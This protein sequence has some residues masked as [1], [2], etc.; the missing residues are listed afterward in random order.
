LQSQPGHRS[1]YVHS[2]L[3]LGWQVHT[4]VA[5]I[6]P[7]RWGLVDIFPPDCP[8]TTILPI[9]AFQQSRITGLSHCTWL[10]F[11]FSMKSNY[12]FGEKFG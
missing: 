9:S 5:N 2:S 8:Q 12:S 1:S 3:Y 10:F 7:L 6:F 11:H 4:T